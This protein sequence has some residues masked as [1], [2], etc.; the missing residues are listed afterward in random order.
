VLDPVV[1][2]NGVT[3][4]YRVAAITL[5]QYPRPEMGYRVVLGLVRAGEEHGA[6][7][8]DAACARALD[9]GGSTAPHR[10]YIEAL[11][12]V[13]LERVPVRQ[14]KL[15]PLGDHETSEAAT[16]TTGRIEMLIE[17]TLQKMLALRM[18]G[19][20]AATRELIESAPSNQLSFEDRLGIIVDREWSDRDSRR[21]ARRIREAKISTRASLEAV[22]C[23]AARGV[24]KSFVKLMTTCKWVDA[25]QNV[26]ITGATGTGKSFLGAALAEAACRHGPGAFRPRA[27]PRRGPRHRARTRRS[28]PSSSSHAST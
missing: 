6:A 2:Q 7:R 23:D 18:P 27:A 4:P 3:S 13:G 28:S 15:R 11:L 14:E 24:Y 26:L 8:F 16:T 10:K 21:V 20:A 19:M 12:R 25:H 17:E 1:S 5:A 9:V 22:E